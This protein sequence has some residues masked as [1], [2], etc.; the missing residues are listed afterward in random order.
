MK[1][2][3]RKNIIFGTMGVKQNNF[4]SENSRQ[5]EEEQKEIIRLLTSNHNEAYKYLYDHYYRPLMV[6]AG[7]YL[8]NAEVARDLVQETFISLLSVH[9]RF[10]NMVHLKSY[11]YSTLYHKCLNHLRHEKT[12]QQFIQKKLEQAEEQFEQ[13]LIEEEVYSLLIS[14]IE[15]LSPQSREVMLLSLDGL[16][17]AEIAQKLQLS[18]ETV[19]TYRKNGKKKIMDYFSG[20]ELPAIVLFIANA[21]LFP[22]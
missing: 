17:N 19:K 20:K 9:A 22:S 16:S 21:I 15:T 1:Q 11:L 12:E 4:R 8:I 14:A 10:A 6:F 3:K 7:H 5:T 13:I 2:R 18:V